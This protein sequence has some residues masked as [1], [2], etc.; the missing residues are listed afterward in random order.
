M[1]AAKACIRVSFRTVLV[2]QVMCCSANIAQMAAA[3]RQLLLQSRL[4]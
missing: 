1:P 3:H 2:L 4:T